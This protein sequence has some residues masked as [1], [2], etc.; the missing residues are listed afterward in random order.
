[1]VLPGARQA[2]EGSPPVFNTDGTHIN[3]GAIVVTASVNIANKHPLTI[4]F[5]V[6]PSENTVSY[7]EFLWL[8]NLRLGVNREGMVVISDRDKVLIP[9]HSSF[10]LG[11]RTLVGL[12][13]S[14]D[15]MSQGLS[16][17]IAIVL[18]VVVQLIC[19][20]HLTGNARHHSNV[21]LFTS[22]FPFYVFSASTQC[23]IK[24]FS[25]LPDQGSRI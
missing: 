23:N 5:G 6:V 12:C 25:I 17:A 20:W 4:G 13:F 16:A 18:T 1:M 19:L 7:S 24:L 15:V 14:H 22:H 2:F 8:L 10:Y 3:C 11:P 21:L 9:S